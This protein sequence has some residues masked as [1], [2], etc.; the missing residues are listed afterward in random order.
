MAIIRPFSC[1]L[2]NV[3]IRR[4]LSYI[5]AS[6]IAAAGMMGG[7]A[8]A[9]ASGAEGSAIAEW[10]GI[11]SWAAAGVAAVL[12]D[13]TVPARAVGF[14]SMALPLVWF[15]M[16][17]VSEDRSLWFM[18]LLFIGLFALVA[19]LSAAGTRLLFRLAARRA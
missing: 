15:G 7:H 12:I 11:L 2:L 16:L 4:R 10:M 19:G 9:G 3:P 8:L 6:V 17:L 5:A 1:T 13:R 14:A 18:G